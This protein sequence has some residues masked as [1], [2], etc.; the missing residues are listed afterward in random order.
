M[1]MPLP[2]V[3]PVLAAGWCALHAALT[4]GLYL[5]G[6]PRRNLSEQAILEVL[7]QKRPPHRAI[8]MGLRGL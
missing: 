4:G 2:A 8:T 7:G 5:G 1:Y 6:S 3:L